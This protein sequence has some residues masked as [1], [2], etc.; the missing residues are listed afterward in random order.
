M[1]QHEY[2]G[3]SISL[4][5]MFP[6]LVFHPFVQPLISIALS[7]PHSF[8]ISLSHSHSLSLSLSHKYFFFYTSSSLNNGEYLPHIYTY[9]ACHNAKCDIARSSYFHNVDICVLLPVRCLFFFPSVGL[10][11]ILIE[12]NIY[13]LVN[14]TTEYHSDFA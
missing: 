8:S 7:A 9:S 2:C 12:Y 6:L 5:P 4:L 11:R 13:T 14:S 10:Y 1:Q 3:S